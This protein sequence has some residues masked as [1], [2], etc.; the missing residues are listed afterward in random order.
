MG[1]GVK[2]TMFG[3]FYVTEQYFAVWYINTSN[4]TAV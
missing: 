3:N 1:S 4:N 2:I